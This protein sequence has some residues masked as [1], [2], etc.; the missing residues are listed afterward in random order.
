MRRFASPEAHLHFDLVTLLEEATCRA[1]PDLQ[2]VIVGAR[3]QPDLLD[4][5]DVLVLARVARALV[6]FEL[7]LAEIGDAAHRRIGGRG[8]LD[9]IKTCLLGA[10]D[11]FF[12]REDPNLLAVD[13]QDANFG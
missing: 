2:V 5:G 8:D 6:L 13:V 12:D 11:S 10:P 7:E 4:L 3:A 9:Q 1:N